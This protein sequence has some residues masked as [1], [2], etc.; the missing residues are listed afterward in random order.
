M[1]FGLGLGGSLLAGFGTAA[2]TPRSWIHMVI[3]AG[4]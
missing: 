4:T 1:L 3:F 2:A